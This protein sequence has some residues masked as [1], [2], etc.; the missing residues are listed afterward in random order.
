[1]DVVDQAKEVL[2][3]LPGRLEMWTD[4]DV[5]KVEP[6]YLRIKERAKYCEPEIQA[7]VSRFVELY[8]SDFL[9]QDCAVYRARI[10]R[11]KRNLNEV[12]N[13]Q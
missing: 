6:L 13:K 10:W 2:S 7:A 1:M 5:A 9:V 8:E 12:I 4:A 11:A 3:F